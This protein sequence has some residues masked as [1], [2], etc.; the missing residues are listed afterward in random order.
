MPATHDQSYGTGLSQDTIVKI[1]EVKRLMDKYPK[2]HGN[3][4]GIIQWAIHSCLSQ[5]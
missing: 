3:P 1:E 5:L 4:D 2:H